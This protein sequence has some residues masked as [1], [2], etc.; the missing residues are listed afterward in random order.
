V[1]ETQDP[2]LAGGRRDGEGLARAVALCLARAGLPAG[3]IGA[4]V[5]SGAWTQ[6]TQ[7]A[8]RAALRAIFGDGAPPVHSVVAQTGFLPAAGA[9]LDIAAAV[10]LVSEGQAAGHV[11]VM[12]GDITGPHAAM[13]IS[14]PPDGR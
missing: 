5:A 13:I 1:A 2:K 12:G 6:A 10:R 11:L 7:E 3:D 9:L 8:Q 4:V 14:R